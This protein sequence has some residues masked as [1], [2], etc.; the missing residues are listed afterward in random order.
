M[1]FGLGI[2]W[3][4]R[5][6][7][8]TLKGVRFFQEGMLPDSDAGVL[9]LAF[10]RE[11]NRVTGPNRDGFG[12]EVVLA[13]DAVQTDSKD[14]LFA[15]KSGRNLERL[16][17]RGSDLG[18]AVHLTVVDEEENHIGP[19]VILDFEDHRAR[20]GLGDL[21]I[22]LE[23]RVVSAGTGRQQGDH[24]DVRGNNSPGDYHSSSTQAS[25]RHVAADKAMWCMAHA[26][27]RV[28]GDRPS[29]RMTPLSDAF[30]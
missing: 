6:T 29:A 11:S 9:E 1:L 17:L 8:F 30:S 15:N 25:R 23:L 10:Y 7:L 14:S 20:D 16:I 13:P 27:S 28:R 3:T 24:G 5:R 19:I 22:V 18:E 4:P 21:G 12:P 2:S 26:A